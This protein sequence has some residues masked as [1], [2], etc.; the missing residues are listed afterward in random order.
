VN[1]GV[2]PKTDLRGENVK[3]VRS[4]TNALD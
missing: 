1:R 2:E 3:T 4:E